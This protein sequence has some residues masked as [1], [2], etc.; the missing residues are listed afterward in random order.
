[1]SYFSTY[2]TIHVAPVD[3]YVAIFSDDNQYKILPVVA[4]LTQE[5]YHE[6]SERDAEQQLGIHPWLIA[7]EGIWF[8][9]STQSRTVYGVHTDDGL[10]PADDFENFVGVYRG[11]AEAKNYIR[12][13]GGTY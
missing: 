5:I 1:M 10:V 3:G 11:F 12:R 7:N 8:Y 4:I 9:P 6:A 2:K 13:I